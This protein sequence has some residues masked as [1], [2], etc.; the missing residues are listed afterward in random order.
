MR[1]MKEIF[2][3]LSKASKYVLF[4]V[5]LMFFGCAGSEIDTII[6]E[7]EGV[8]L[9]STRSVNRT[10]END[11]ITVGDEQ[12]EIVDNIGVIVTIGCVY[13]TTASRMTI[14]VTYPTINSKGYLI[15]KEYNKFYDYNFVGTNIYEWCEPIVSIVED[16][17]DIEDKV[18]IPVDDS[19]SYLYMDITTNDG[20]YTWS[21]KSE[22]VWMRYY[23]THKDYTFRYLK[24]ENSEEDPQHYKARLA[25]PFNNA[26]AYNYI[27][28][29]DVRL[30]D[31]YGNWGPKHLGY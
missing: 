6:S 24:L 26:D 23:F 4:C 16:Q 31:S 7:T 22:H 10:F 17:L 12:Y 8:Q 18:C 15:Y 9:S 30:S 27:Y 28:L 29:G 20:P 2:F 1:N 11:I 21:G 13:A 3:S 14:K 19:D 25:I 5:L